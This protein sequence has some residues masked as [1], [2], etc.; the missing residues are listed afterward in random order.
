MSFRIEFQSSSTALFLS[1]WLLAAICGGG[2]AEPRVVVA[3]RI[4]DTTPRFAT[5]TASALARPAGTNAGSY[6]GRQTGFVGGTGYAVGGWPY[7]YSVRLA[8][9]NPTYPFSPYGTPRQFGAHDHGLQHQ[10]HPDQARYNQFGRNHWVVQPIVPCPRPWPVCPQ[11]CPP[12]CGLFR[13]GCFPYPGHVG[14]NPY[15]TPFVFSPPVVCWNPWGW[16]GG[17]N[18]GGGGFGFGFH[19]G[20][21]QPGVFGFQ[22]Q[23]MFTGQG[24]FFGPGFGGVWDDAGRSASGARVSSALSPVELP[25]APGAVADALIQRQAADVMAQHRAVAEMETT[26]GQQRTASV[27]A[28]LR[29]PLGRPT[30]ATVEKSSDSK[31][32]RTYPAT[33]VRGASEPAQPKST[34][35]LSAAESLAA[36]KA[37]QS[38]AERQRLL[39]KLREK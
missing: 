27:P 34:V 6:A 35:A 11:P 8:N 9:Q 5:D 21:P 14:W 17:W 10:R 39:K 31:D 23:G 1:G 30:V 19:G 32:G 2:L 37:A 38:E 33:A 12:G 18:F 7:G 28:N 25:R 29:D 3:Q 24:Q 4:V 16:N 13:P 36:R 20:F 26:L 22:G 15:C